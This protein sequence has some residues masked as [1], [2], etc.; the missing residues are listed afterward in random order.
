MSEA[1]EVETLDPQAVREKVK[2]RLQAKRYGIPD[3]PASLAE[4]TDMALRARYKD[5]EFQLERVSNTHTEIAE[6]RRLSPEGKSEKLAEIQNSAIAEIEKRHN[7]L[8][9]E[10]HAAKL[11][12]QIDQAAQQA[13]A[14]SGRQ[15]RYQGILT[16]LNSQPPEQRNAAWLKARQGND[17]EFVEAVYQTNKTI[18]SIL[19]PHLRESDLNGIADEIRARYAP[20]QVKELSALDTEIDVLQRTVTAALQ[21]V[22]RKSL[23]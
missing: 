10:Q 5:I 7:T 2:A 1:A 19:L 13:L 9:A 20:E 3:W 22:R 16:W 21:Y 6:D 4:T 17:A 18:R 23:A 14:D 11:R 8:N 15:S 12:N